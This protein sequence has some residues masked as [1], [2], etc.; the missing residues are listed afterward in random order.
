MLRRKLFTDAC[1]ELLLLHEKAWEEK[2]RKK[3]SPKGFFE[4]M[5][6]KVGVI[7]Y[8]YEKVVMWG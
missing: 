6:M 4:N 1:R 7:V 2:K 3:K 5:S 8:E